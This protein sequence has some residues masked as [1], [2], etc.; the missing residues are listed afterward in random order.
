MCLKP[1]LLFCVGGIKAI[2]ALLRLKGSKTW[3][4]VQTLS[5]QHRYSAHWIKAHKEIQQEELLTG[6]L[7]GSD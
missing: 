2:T 3:P 6:Q 5:H 1:L 7:S 4:I